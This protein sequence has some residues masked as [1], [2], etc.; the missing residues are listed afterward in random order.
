MRTSSSKKVKTFTPE[1]LTNALLVL[2]EQVQESGFYPE[3]VVGIASGG[4]KCTSLLASKVDIKIYECV[5][6]RP[7]TATKQKIPV[8]RFL[9]YVPYFI[10]DIL[11]VIEDR[12]LER[13]TNNGVKLAASDRSVLDT[14][15]ERIASDIRSQGMSRVLIVDD[16]VDSG[17]T[18][19]AVKSRLAAAMGDGCEVRTA[20]VTTTRESCLERPD[21]SFLQ[22][23]L[24][25]FPWS[26]DYRG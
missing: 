10:T 2:W 26:F 23:T 21:Y 15:C 3:A 6:R 1:E 25:R 11:R 20:V 5:L 4:T 13:S 12:R 22:R 14:H 7:S 16:A 9:R 17:H 19:H 18:L 24:C 8:T